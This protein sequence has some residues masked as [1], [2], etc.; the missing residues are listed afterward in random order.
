MNFTILPN[1]T[2][3]F[4]TLFLII[5]AGII[6]GNTYDS[7]CIIITSL[8]V[9][10]HQGFDRDP[11]N[12]EN[13]IRLESWISKLPLSKTGTSMGAIVLVKHFQVL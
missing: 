8:K 1:H 6:S 11:D 10:S 7:R 4:Y 9:Y 12:S 3:S 2:D 13:S 5:L